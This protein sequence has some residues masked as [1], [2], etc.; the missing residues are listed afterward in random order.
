MVANGLI[1]YRME[2]EQKR[3]EDVREAQLKM[4][5]QQKHLQW[6]SNSKLDEEERTSDLQIFN[7]IRSGLHKELD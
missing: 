6:H 7:T 4:L 2:I 3:A 1:F 5:I